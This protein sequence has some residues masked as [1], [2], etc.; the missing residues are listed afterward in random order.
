ML[1]VPNVGPTPLQLTVVLASPA[2]VCVC[3]WMLAAPMSYCST[4]GGVGVMGELLDV[5]F[6]CMTANTSLVSAGGPESVSVCGPA[7]PGTVLDDAN[8]PVGFATSAFSY[9]NTWMSRE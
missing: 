8:T 1:V 9:A 4:H 2:R 7:P 3:I 6:V 5:G